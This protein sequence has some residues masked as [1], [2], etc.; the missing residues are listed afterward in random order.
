[1]R[2]FALYEQEGCRF[3]EAGCRTREYLCAGEVNHVVFTYKD[4]AKKG[5]AGGKPRF[6]R[7]SPAGASSTLDC[8]LLQENGRP[9]WEGYGVAGRQRLF[10]DGTIPA[11][12]HRKEV[13]FSN[14]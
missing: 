1:M 2:N 10:P 14:S 7:F 3:P 13:S 11:S 8:S 5:E 9:R 4:K 6:G 12:L